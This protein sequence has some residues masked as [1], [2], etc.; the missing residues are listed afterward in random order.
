MKI[1]IIGAGSSYTPELVLKLSEM[2][3]KLPVS[4]IAL[5]DIDQSRLDI[6]HG[7]CKRYAEGLNYFVEFTKTL[8]KRRAVEGADFI[9]TQIRVGGNKARVSDEKIP[10]SYGLIG[11][12]TTGA[13]G[14][15]KALRTIPAIVD[16]AKCVEELSPGAWI[17]NYTNPTG[18]I[19]ESVY[20]TTKAKIAGLCAGGMFPAHWTANALNV[21]A[22]CVRYDYAG[23]NHMNFAYNITVNGKALTDNE[24]E[25]VMLASG[26]ADIELLKSIGAA[27][28]PYLPYY[29]H[30]G[31]IIEQLKN[32]PATRGEEVLALEKEIFDGYAD[33]NN[34]Q[35]PQALHKRGGG[36]Y[37]DVAIGV[38]D[39]IYNNID[40]FMVVNVP[41]NRVLSFLP[42]DAVIE[43]ACMVNAG[44]IKSVAIAPPPKAVWGLIAAVKNYEQLT[45]EAALTGCRETALAALVAHPLVRDYDIAKPLLAELLEA[46]KNYLPQFFKGASK[47]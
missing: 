3:D 35:V 13:G 28:S 43:T 45:V 16:I 37:S 40:T 11:Q 32:A 44:G 38:I 10:I 42:D 8:D 39:A 23:L 20:K 31:R 29:F 1:T 2:R 17:I 4:E 18:I 46:N 5:M 7:F 19:A 26:G 41:N 21:P 33:E 24:M 30:T 25:K 22:G 14:F 6:M 36:G 34:N 47:L 12:E 27:A 9:V 15:M